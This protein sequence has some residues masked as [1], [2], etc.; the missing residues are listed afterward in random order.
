MGRNVVGGYARIWGSTSRYAWIN[1]SVQDK[2]PLYMQRDYPP[3]NDNA[4]SHSRLSD[5]LEM[6]HNS[7][8]FKV[9]RII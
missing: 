5:E 1:L 2:I 8:G 7:P 4:S 3:I 9:N 6:R